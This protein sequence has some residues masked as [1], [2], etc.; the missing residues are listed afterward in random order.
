MFYEYFPHDLL[1]AFHFLNQVSQREEQ[2]V[3]F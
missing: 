2:A 1:L 3:L